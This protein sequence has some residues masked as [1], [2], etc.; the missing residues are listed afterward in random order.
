MLAIEVEFLTGRYA[1]TTHN[2]RSRAEW[3]PHPVRFF[4]ALVAA[5]HD[6]DPVDGVERDALTWVERQP[7]PSLDVDLSVGAEV[8]RRR[9]LDVYVPVNDVTLVGDV[10]APLRAARDRLAAL[11]AERST[12]DR[13]LKQARKQIENEEKNL[14]ATLAKQQTVDA[15][16]AKSAL[17]TAT[18]LLPDRRTRQVRTFPVVVPSRS[19]FA[20]VWRD[21]PPPAVRAGLNS[22]CDRVTRLGHSSSLVR[23]AVI[24]RPTRPTLVPHDDGDVV[25]RV[26][27]P[28]QLV[29]LEREFERHQGV[30]SRNL[31]FRPQRYGP[32]TLR[33]EPDVTPRSAFSG[34]WIVFERVGGARPLSSRGTDLTRALRAALL[35]QHGSETLPGSISGHGVGGTALAAARVAFIALPFVDHERADASVMG[36]ALVLPRDLTVEDRETLFRLVASWE[37]TRSV[38]DDGTTVELAGGTLS[39]VRVRRCVEP[40]EKTSLRP[41]RWSRPS[42]R[43]VTATPIALDRN[44]GNL[45]SVCPFPRNDHCRSLLTTSTRSTRPYTDVPP[46]RGKRASCAQSW[47]IE[48]GPA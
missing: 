7:P 41:N 17:A 1:A 2:D 38:A 33:V 8:G 47:Q 20:F 39:P 24:E 40:S 4:S 29:R 42:T 30:E 19:I 37:R 34:E 13:E 36:C 32:P 14:T 26:T 5:L 35:E 10:E 9:V 44:P 3:P 46:F 45:V 25:L 28:D 12:N 6:R 21:D 11:L 27:G 18:A 48:P 16:P 31:P 15:R 43:F 22:L 23:C